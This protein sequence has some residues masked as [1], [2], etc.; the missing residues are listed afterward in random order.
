MH[1]AFFVHVSS[2]AGFEL[3]ILASAL[4]LLAGL[5]FLLY[6]AAFVAS[7]LYGSLAGAGRPARHRADPHRPGLMAGAE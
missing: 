1:G 2:G 3:A 5:L 4:L 7:M 6:S